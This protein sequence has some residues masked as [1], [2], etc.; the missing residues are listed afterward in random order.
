M[1]KKTDIEYQAV[2]NEV[3]ELLLHNVSRKEI[4]QYISEKEKV[5]ERQV[6]N[7]LAEAYDVISLDFQQ[8]RSKLIRNQI[9]RLNDLYEKNSAIQDY[10]EC[11]AIV[12]ET[13]KL[14]GLN[15]P[16]QI[17]VTS[18]GE[19]LQLPPWVREKDA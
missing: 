3:I 18:G 8:I 15:A 12:G 16:S 11:R 5:S 4:L 10:R 1:G 19:K 17:D 14:F 7:Y 6:E 13:S 2:V 9:K